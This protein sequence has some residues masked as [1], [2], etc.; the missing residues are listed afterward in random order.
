LVALPQFTIFW[1]PVMGVSV[2]RIIAALGLGDKERLVVFNK[3]DLIDPDIAFK[4]ATRHEGVAV[5]ALDRKSFPPLL[6]ELE[7]RLWLD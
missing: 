2:N 5:S 6:A 4:I 7:H 1:P 3:C